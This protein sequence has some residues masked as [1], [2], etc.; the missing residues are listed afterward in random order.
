MSIMYRCQGDRD[1]KQCE[2]RTTGAWIGWCCG[3]P[4]C[5]SGKPKPGKPKPDY[6]NIKKDMASQGFM[7]KQYDVKYDDVTL[8]VLL[9]RDRF[10]RREH[11]QLDGEATPFE[12]TPAQRAAISAHW[13]AELRAKV[14][15]AKERDRNQVTMEHDE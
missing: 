4:A 10:N 6:A 7:Y 9:E 12:V 3:D 2:T 8:R 11:A 13:F 14:A 5:S 15:A 1:G